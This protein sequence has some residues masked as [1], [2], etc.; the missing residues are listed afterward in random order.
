MFWTALT[1]LLSAPPFSYPVGVIG[2]FGLFGLA[3]AIAAQRAGRLHDRGWSVPATGIGWVLALVA[4][5]P[6]ALAG[7]SVVVLIAAIVLPDVAIQSLNIL[8][9]TRLFAVA[10]NARGRVNTATVTANFV[11]GAIGSAAAGLLWSTGGWAAVTGVG[12]VL[13]GLG[14]GVW[15]AGR[16]GPLLLPGP[17]SAAV[18][19]VLSDGDCCGSG[20]ADQLAS[21]FSFSSDGEPGCAV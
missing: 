6:A 15:A 12:L 11:A 17:R 3:G 13:C 4:F 10:G 14:L 1:F 8:N 9:S 2:L 20:V 19:Q 5:G 7:H 16:R 21:R 18:G